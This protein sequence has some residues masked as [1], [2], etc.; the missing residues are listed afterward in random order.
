MENISQEKT[1]EAVSTETSEKSQDSDIQFEEVI[2]IDKIQKELREQFGDGTQED[3]LPIEPKEDSAAENNLDENESLEFSPPQEAKTG[4]TRLVVDPKD[5]KYVVYIDYENIDFM[6]NL[7]N[8]ERKEMIN[9]ILKEQNAYV[10]RQKAIDDRK[11]FIQHSII[12]T[13]TFIIGF[14]LLFLS[15]NKAMEFTMQ[16]YKE[17]KG[18][19]AKL[20][21]E[22][23]KIKSDDSAVTNFKY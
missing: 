9:K 7:S 21:K 1:E 15:V 5:K 2:D 20:Y 12:A 4:E 8:A 10:I 18:N 11:R 6:E 13:I 17:A 19:F 23:G 22:Q 3:E 14:P 16:N